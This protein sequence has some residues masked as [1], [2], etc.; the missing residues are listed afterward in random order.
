MSGPRTLAIRVL[1][2]PRESLD[3][4]L[5][6]L[7]RRSW[8]S[9]SALLDALGLP[10][11]TAR[12]RTSRLLTSLPEG[13]LRQLEQ[14]VS[15]PDRHLDDAVLPT[16]IFGRRAPGWRFCPQC[17]HEA[18]GRWP[19]LWWLPWAFACTK[20]HALLHRVCP[21]CGREP[22]YFLPRAVHQHPPGHCMRRTGG[23]NV[24]GADLGSAPQLSLGHSHP[25]VQTQTEINGI[26]LHPF[27]STDAVFVE[28]D[29]LLSELDGSLRPSGLQTM[30]TACR[31]AW[32]SAF[33]DATNS[34]SSLGR[35]RFHERRARIL[36][37]EFLQHEYTEGGK[38]LTTISRELGLPVV[39]VI[40]QAKN[41]GVHI[42]RGPRPPA[43]NDDWLRE[44]YVTHKRTGP[45]IAQ[46]FGTHTKAVHRRLEQLGIARRASGHCS[47]ALIKKLDTSIPPDIRAAAEETLHGWRRLRRFQISIFFPTLTTSADYL[48]LQPGTLTMQLDQLECAVGAELFRRSVR[49]TPQSPTKRGARLLRDLDRDDVQELIHAA[50]GSKIEK[51]PDEEAISSAI[52]TADGERGALIDL[53][54]RSQHGGR[55]HIPPLMLPLLR[56]LFTRRD[57]EN[58]MAQIHA[59][60]GMPT[61][62][63]FK[64]LKRL[65]E[66]G[67]LTSRRETPAE[68]P[69]GGRGRTYYSL[70]PLAQRLQ[71][72]LT[73]LTETK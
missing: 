22:R 21:S 8:T 70:T 11:L 55:L 65:E 38:N 51:I 7:A 32:E 72:S 53:H 58:C 52:S 45:D 35:W 3:S 48:G 73:Q 31:S 10:E 15:L 42:F 64:Q 66:A 12:E 49:H 9:I 36:T 67:W 60:T 61:T 25:I 30:S 54:P 26:T 17:L 16:E 69:N 6:A 59:T 4:W 19:T 33:T 27:T 44:Q 20:H 47:A 43:F 29:R 62:T 2:Q 28:V 37:P 57:Q 24:C 50:L 13:A 56:H 1:P 63:I 18:E 46:E 71:P 68:R 41:L 14:Q 23:R 5:E 39:H 34:R 40:R